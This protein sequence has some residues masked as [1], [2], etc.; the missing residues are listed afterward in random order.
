MTLKLAVEVFL[1]SAFALFVDANS[2]TQK[3]AV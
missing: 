3:S 2:Q 1:L